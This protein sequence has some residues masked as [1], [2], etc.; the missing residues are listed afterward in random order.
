M[1]IPGLIFAITVSGETTA[2]SQLPEDILSILK[3]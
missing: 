1:L 3:A 2:D